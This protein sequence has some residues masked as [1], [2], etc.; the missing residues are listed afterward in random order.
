MGHPVRVWESRDSQPSEPGWWFASDGRWYPPEAQP[1]LPSHPPRRRA[2]VV[3]ALVGGGLALVLTAIAIV[4][5]LG[6]TDNSQ[7]P[8]LRRVSERLAV[9]AT[10]TLVRRGEE[11]GSS[12]LCIISCPHAEIDLDFRVPGEPSHGSVCAALRAIVDRD[13]AP[14]QTYH[15][16]CGWRAPVAEAG[17]R[18]MVTA[19]AAHACDSGGL[20]C[21]WVSFSG[22]PT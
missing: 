19:G 4:V 17:S 11:P 9:P 21:V 16:D 3:V 20:T 13:I 18:A 8:K 2:W 5:V 22:G 1:R 14:T 6:R 10:W 12:R 15:A 7:L